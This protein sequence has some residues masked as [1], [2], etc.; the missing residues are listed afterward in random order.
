MG[1]PKKPQPKFAAVAPQRSDQTPRTLTGLNT[2]NEGISEAIAEETPKIRGRE[3]GIFATFRKF[4]FRDTSAAWT[5]V[6]TAVLAVFTYLLYRVADRTDETART[7]QRAFVSFKDLQFSLRVAD[8]T[9]T[10]LLAYQ[11]AGGWE[12]SGT[13]PAR[14]GVS[15]ISYRYFAGPMPTDFDFK[16]IVT[17]ETNPFVLGPKATAYVV[18]VPPIPMTVFI[19][20]QQGTQHLYFWGWTTYD[21]IFPHSIRHLTEFC[22]EITQVVSSLPDIT[23]PKSQFRIGSHSCPTHNCYD[24]DCPDYTER[25]K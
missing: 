21:D 7:A 3:G 2:M 6:F 8:P 4:M 13:T 22:G 25:I 15:R 11:M 1:K 19:G 10:K 17:D 23:D 20:I 18:L 16:D 9:G 24:E 14:R 12:N 5:A